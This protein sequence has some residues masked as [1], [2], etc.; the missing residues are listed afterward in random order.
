MLFFQDANHNGAR[1]SP[2]LRASWIKPSTSVKSNLPSAGSIN[3]QSPGTRTVLRLSATSLGPMRRIYSRLEEDELP[4]SPP[5][6]RKALPSTIS[7][8]AEPCLRRCGSED[9]S[10]PR[11]ELGQATV[12]TQTVAKTTIQRLGDC[13]LVM[14]FVWGSGEW[15]V[16]SGEWGIASPLPTP[17]SP[18]YLDSV[19]GCESAGPLK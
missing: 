18:G 19:C 14:S 9:G 17:H 10:A 11:M 13:K 8:V 6:T 4:S 1:R 2:C 5:R 15:G 7:C 12:K 3:S 16:G